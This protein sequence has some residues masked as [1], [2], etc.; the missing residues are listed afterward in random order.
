MMPLVTQE[1]KRKLTQWVAKRPHDRRFREHSEV[2]D[3][4]S[5]PH[6]T[7]TVTDRRL[8]WLQKHIPARAVINSRSGRL[9]PS[10]VL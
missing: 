3:G 10:K 8:M 6:W 1:K 4:S 7:L 9:K 2:E 5:H